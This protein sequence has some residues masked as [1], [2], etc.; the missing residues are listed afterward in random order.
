[1]GDLN[2]FSVTSPIEL[3]GNLVTKKFQFDEIEIFEGKSPLRH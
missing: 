2:K 3:V 1:M